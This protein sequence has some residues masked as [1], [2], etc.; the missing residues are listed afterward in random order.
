MKQE[1]MVPTIKTWPRIIYA[2][3]LLKSG[4]F[5]LSKLTHSLAILTRASRKI[6]LRISLFS[7]VPLLSVQAYWALGPP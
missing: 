7:Y 2:A 5:R 1:Q 6:G 4:Y 3:Q